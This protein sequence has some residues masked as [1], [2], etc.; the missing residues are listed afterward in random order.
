M[1]ILLISIVP[2][3]VLAEGKQ[4]SII[5]EVE[6]DVEE[7]KDY[8]ETYHPFVEVV[9]TYETLLNG[10]AIQGSPKDID[11]L[12]NLQF[13]KKVH[14]VQQYKA[15]PY[16]EL[17]LKDIGESVLPSTLND[18]TYTG[19]GVKVGVI[20]TGIDYKH[21]DL[22]KNYKQGYD[23][24]DL[25]KDPMETTKEEGLPTLHGSHV[26]GIIAADGEL[27]GVAPDAEIYAYRALGPG[28]AGSS[29]QVLAA[30]EQAVKD[31]VDVIN[32]SL[33][34]I[35]NGPDYP[36]SAA[37]NKAVELG[38]PVVIANGNSGPNRWTVGAPATAINAL[39]V[40]ASTNVIH[41]P[42][43]TE[44][45]EDKKIPLQMMLGSSPWNFTKAY[46][47]VQGLNEA[48]LYG[49]IVIVERGEIPFYQLA[50][51]AEEKGA[52]ALLI[53]N[54]E[55]QMFQGS[56][57]GGGPPVEIPV[58]LISKEDGK[59]VQS[60]IG[61]KSFYMETTYQKMDTTIA[62]FSSRGPVTVNWDIKPDILAPGTNVVSTVPG[63]Y[64]ALQGTSMA[65]P[66]VTGVIALIKEAQPDW[67]TEQIY[68]AIRTTA[69]PLMGKEGEFLPPIEQ[70]MGIIQPLDAIQTETIIYN[71]KLVFGKVEGSY[72]E[73]LTYN[74]KIENT[75]N[76]AQTYR[77]DIP[78]K[79]KG[80]S[81]SFPM[82]VQL[83][84]KEKI[85]IPVELSVTPSLL[86]EGLHQGWI[87]LNGSNRVYHLPY[88]FVNQ[89]ADNP[90]AM[91]FEFT[92]KPFSE[93]SYEYGLYITDPTERV[94]VDLYDPQTLMFNRT[95]LVTDQVEV[96]MNEGE[97]KKKEV[98]SS[99]EYLAVVT[100]YLLNGKTET[101]E[102]MLFI[103]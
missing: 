18:T 71:P 45:M 79:Q 39:S 101:Y 10:L 61:G 96:G 44:R 83:D 82:A 21:P 5:I 9:A 86:E 84:A 26:A 100:V 31:E 88:L 4:T 76:D 89:S 52:V 81:W 93:K 22:K 56:I 30:M 15:H 7:H 72:R 92:L 17:N 36:T 6:G 58:A 14:S 20:D 38:I 32:L 37:V 28:G 78:K 68:G 75:S 42:F 53:Q 43:L 102:T 23:L 64:Q 41:I 49:K 24:V 63:G 48:N 3:L 11:R 95:L 40:G 27:K 19:K 57:E 51:E 91:G 62:S 2:A 25:D 103:P 13:I 34:N 8:L 46:P 1:F 80:L 97:L 50:K 59:W 77:F 16:E 70:G 66:H 99:G 98:G 54:N 87:A 73:P 74:L 90:K 12:K 47:V 94:E 65:A 29:I 55:E 35:V 69:D 33:G 60:Q 67:S 85:E